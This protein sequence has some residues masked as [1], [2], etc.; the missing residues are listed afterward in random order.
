MLLA[1]AAS[2]ALILLLGRCLRRE[3][4]CHNWGRGPAPHSAL[5]RRRGEAQLL[6]SMIGL[7][8]PIAA[9]SESAALQ[10]KYPRVPG[11]MP[12]GAEMSSSAFS[13]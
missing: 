8:A 7:A 5:P 2:L 1:A 12:L 3:K 13:C 6:G 11:P 4:Y 9:P 10:E